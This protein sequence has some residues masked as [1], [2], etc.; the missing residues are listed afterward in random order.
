MTF[1]MSN[2]IDRFDLV[3]DVIDRCRNPQ[4]PRTT[5]SRHATELASARPLPSW[6]EIRA[7]G[8]VWAR[9]P[10]PARHRRGGVDIG[11]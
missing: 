1:E 3:D 10:L 11:Q 8:S 5:Y 9:L 2:D 4:L 7:R 6:S